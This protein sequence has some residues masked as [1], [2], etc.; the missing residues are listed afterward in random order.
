MHTLDMAQR[1]AWLKQIKAIEN[2]NSLADRELSIIGRSPSQQGFVHAEAS[3]GRVQSQIK[4][5]LTLM[6]E[7]YH[8]G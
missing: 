1:Y 2:N 4:A 7:P 8:A 6:L 3:D 5:G